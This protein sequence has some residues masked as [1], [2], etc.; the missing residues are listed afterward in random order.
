[1]NRFLDLYAGCFYA[2]DDTGGAAGSTPTDSRV[3]SDLGAVSGAGADD[4][5]AD[6]DDDA[7]DA[8]QFPAS[9][10][11]KLRRENAQQRKDAAELKARLDALE[12]EKLTDS[13]KRDKRLKALEEENARVK[14]EARAA[15][16]ESLAAKA[17][18]TDADVVALLIPADAEDPSKA[19][20]ALKRERPHLFGGTRPGSADAGAGNAG[21]P[22]GSSVNE[23]IRRATGRA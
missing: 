1:M 17:G 12:S 18:A 8:K 19:I 10:V 20:A 23:M 13:E 7:D 6:A 9:V 14:A 2:G 5:K 16:L 3:D 11:R 21:K 4:G 15:R 22:G